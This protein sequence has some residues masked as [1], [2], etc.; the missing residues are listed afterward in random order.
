MR[1]NY[2]L[3]HRALIEKA[4]PVML[5]LFN[6]WK[7]CPKLSTEDWDDDK[8]PQFVLCLDYEN[9]N[10]PNECHN[11]HAALDQV[12]AFIEGMLYHI[13]LSLK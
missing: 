2:P 5:V 12:Q 3:E 7:V 13:S 9:Q 8:D 1:V 11:T 10:D 6:D 4:F